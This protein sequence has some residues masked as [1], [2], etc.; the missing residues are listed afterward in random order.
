ME[1]QPKSAD[2]HKMR[3][4]YIRFVAM[5]VTSTAVMYALTYTNVFDIAHIRVSEERAYMAIV[6]GSAMAI[7][8]MAFMWHMY[9]S[10]RLNAG[11][12]AGAAVLGVLAFVGSQTQAFV[13]DT[14]Y[15]NAMIPHHSIAILT[16]ERAGIEDL[17][18]RD[19]AQ[20]ISDTQVRE[21]KEMSWL[22]DDI[23]AHGKATTTDAAAARPVPE[24]APR[25]SGE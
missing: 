11:I 19:L 12:M 15:M 16:S 7:V 14:A 8:M 2:D 18:V 6:M 9:P 4:R 25:P 24:F 10:R 13:D 1:S 23:A 21:I 17:R 5:I 22:V 3:S 20:G